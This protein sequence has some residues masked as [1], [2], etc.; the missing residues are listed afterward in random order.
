MVLAWLV[1]FS[2]SAFIVTGLGEQNFPAERE[3]FTLEASRGVRECFIKSFGRF[4]NAV[5]SR[6]DAITSLRY[7]SLPYRYSTVPAS[8]CRQLLSIFP[9]VV[10]EFTVCTMNYLVP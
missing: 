5:V 6:W 3:T 7:H 2:L 9:K 10:V 8:L 1:R 4:M